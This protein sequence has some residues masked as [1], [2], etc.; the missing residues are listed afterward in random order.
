M[1]MAADG[2]KPKL[3]VLILVFRASSLLFPQSGLGLLH[4]TVSQSSNAVSGDQLEFFEKQVRPLLVQNCGRC[5]NAKVRMAGLDL[6][7]VEGIR[8]GG[9]S[10]P[11][12]N[13][14]HPEESR[15]LKVIGY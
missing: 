4:I 11:V 2:H 13:T 10:G 15:L 8:R 7:T 5:H 3:S 1:S 9:D 12:I 6:T 14:E